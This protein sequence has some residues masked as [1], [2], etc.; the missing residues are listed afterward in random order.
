MEQ[1]ER[2]RQAY[3]REG[4]SIREIAKEQHHSRR[5]VK[6]ALE[7]PGPWKYRLSEPRPSPVMESVK[8][9]IDQWLAEDQQRPKKQRHTA[10]QVFKR[11]VQEHLFT[12]AE[13]TVRRYVREHRPETA[14]AR[15]QGAM[16]PLAYRAGEDAQADFGEAEVIL[17]GKRLTVHYCAVRL[18]YSKLPFVLAFPNERQEAF[19][20]GLAQSFEFFGGVPARVS[21]DDPKTLVR[22]ILEG[23]N[24]EEQDAFVTFRSH[25]V[26]AGHFCTPA[27]GHEKGLVENLIGTTRRACFVPLPEVASFAELNEQLRDYCEK[28]KERRRRGETRTVGELWQEERAVLR[29]LPAAAY[30]VGRV[31][32]AV[33]SRSATV[34]F[35]TNRYS[36]PAMYQKREVLIRASVWRVEILANRGT[37]LIASHERSY[38]REE[39]FLDPRHYLGLLAHR[40]GALGHCKAIQQWEREGRWPAIFGQYLTALRAAHPEGGVSAAREYVKILALYA[41]PGG[42]VLPVVLE[43]ALALRCFSLEAVKLLLH[44]HRQPAE[45]PLALDLANRPHLAPLEKVASPQPD[46]HAYDRLLRKLGKILGGRDDEQEGEVA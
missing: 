39:D 25:Y 22:R 4:K 36:V 41:E 8:A 5:V 14:G 32:P 6:A 2:I 46:L 34:Q 42:E 35:E 20:E 38:G 31:V 3:Y 9:I 21:V 1:I 30:P 17:A 18:C 12:G 23:H 11:L 27:E 13:S 19:L 29:P 40:P 33:V 7:D 10:H 26:F 24:R 43:R 15:A 28:E 44:Q 45:H 37:T 16:I